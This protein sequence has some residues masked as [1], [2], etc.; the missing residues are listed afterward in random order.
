MRILITNDDGITA[1][2]LAV[3]SEI[4]LQI[5]GPQGEVWTVAPHFEQ[6]GV[7]HCISYTKPVL[8]HDYGPNI[9]SVEGTPA[10]CVLAGLHDLLPKQPDLILSG[11]NKGNNSA[12]NTLYSGTIGAAIEAALAGIPAI[13][14]SQ[15]YGPKNIN[16]KDTFEASRIHGA[17]AIKS[18]LKAGFKRARGYALFYNINFP[19]VPA[20]KVLGIKAVSQGYRGDGA[21]NVQATIAPNGRKFL[22]VKG[23]SQ[24]TP[25]QA[26][27]DAEANLTGFVSITPMRADLTARDQLAN[28]EKVLG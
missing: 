14:L 18:C 11:V 8:V 19:P 28:L 4:A 24:H 7:G 10:D 13:A 16:L 23:Q 9:Y 15:F 27:T 2:G 26:G 25:T 6:S 5:A 17:A 20:A 3:L 12:E 1:P 21:F 22:F